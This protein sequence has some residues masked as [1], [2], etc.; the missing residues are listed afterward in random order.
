MKPVLA[1]GTH[2]QRHRILCRIE[3]GGTGSGPL[4]G[5]SVARETCRKWNVRG[6]EDWAHFAGLLLFVYLFAFLAEPGF[7]TF[8]RSQEHQADVYGLEVIHGIVP[9]SSAIAAEAFQILGEA[10]LADP[11]PGEFIKV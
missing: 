6:L 3:H 2:T 7:N 1:A 10:H 11:E 5:R 8:S 4:V 9:D